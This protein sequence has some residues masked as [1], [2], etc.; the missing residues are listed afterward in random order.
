M[1]RN[2]LYVVQDKRSKTIIG[3]YESKQLAEFQNPDMEKY[4]FLPFE[5]IKRIDMIQFIMGM[6]AKE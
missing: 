4:E 5:I 3:V 6:E 1:K 2:Y